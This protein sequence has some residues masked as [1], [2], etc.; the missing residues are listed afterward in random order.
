MK[1]PRKWCCAT[2]SRQ[3]AFARNVESITS[4]R[5]CSLLW[6]ATYTGCDCSSIWKYD[7]LFSC[8][9]KK[10]LTRATINYPPSYSVHHIEHHIKNATGDI[11]L[12]QAIASQISLQLNR[13]FQNTNAFDF[14]Q[15]TSPYQRNK[16]KSKIGF[17][18]LCWVQRS[19]RV[20]PGRD[21]YIHVYI[22]LAS[23]NFQYAQRAY[24]IQMFNF[25][26]KVLI[27]RT[28]F[29]LKRAQLFYFDQVFLESVK[30]GTVQ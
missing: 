10:I 25:V 15:L 13:L 22:P 3:R 4:F 7:N 5:C 16:P 14:L 6:S 18:L 1:C 19:I 26:Y 30:H 29:R 8:V 24:R 17:T 9:E 21:I 23:K 20:R 2:N 27:E 28:Q 12:C 11:L